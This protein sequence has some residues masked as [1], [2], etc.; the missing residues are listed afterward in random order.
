LWLQIHKTNSQPT[1]LRKKINRQKNNGKFK[2]NDKANQLP[3]PILMD[4]KLNF[5]TSF[6]RRLFLLLPIMVLLLL[7]KT[8]NKIALSVG[9]KSYDEV[10]SLFDV[11]PELEDSLA[12]ILNEI[13]TSGE[14]ILP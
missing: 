10:T 12:T 9:K 2:K 8:I 13:Y 4:L 6:R 5:K 3:D 11:A 1:P 7:F 14:P